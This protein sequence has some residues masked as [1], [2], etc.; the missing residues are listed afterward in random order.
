[1][2]GTV[3]L[4]IALEYLRSTRDDG[5]YEGPERLQVRAQ[6]RGVSVVGK[7]FANHWLC[8]HN[9]VFCTLSAAERAALSPEERAERTPRLHAWFGCVSAAA[10]KLQRSCACL[11]RYGLLAGGAAGAAVHIFGQRRDG[12]EATDVF[13]YGGR[14]ETDRRG[15]L[16]LPAP[17][18]MQAVAG[19]YALRAVVE[20][21]HSAGEG[22]VF[23]LEARRQRSAASRTHASLIRVPRRTG[24][25]GH[26]LRAVRPGRHAERRR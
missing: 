25:E 10:I 1:V 26:A 3:C 17:A 4:R 16:D 13:R 19:H 9:N 20:T 11:R 5:G 6:P 12:L 21:D 2:V 15:F 18:D 22:S 7:A 8:A 24:A 23:V 14:F